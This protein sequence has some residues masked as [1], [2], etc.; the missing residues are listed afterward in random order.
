MWVRAGSAYENDNEA[1]IAHV[2]EHMLFKGTK[3]RGVGGIAK[4]VD[5]AGGYINAYTSIDMTVYHLAIAS[6]YFDTG[7]DIISDAIQNSSFDPEELKKEESVILEELKMG[8]DEPS[9]RAYEELFATAYE[10]HSYRRPIIGYEETVKSLT[11]E[12]ILNFYKQ[13]YVPNN[14]VFVVVGDFKAEEALKKIKNSF[15]DFK[16]SPLPEINIPVEPVQMHIRS[17]I[18][19]DEIKEANLNFAFHIPALNHEDIPVLDIISVILGQGESSRLYKKIKSDLNLVNSISSYSMTPKYPGLFLAGAAL[20]KEKI[21]EAILPILEEVYLLKTKEVTSEELEKAKLILESDFVYDRETVQGEA[22]KLGYF[23]T[24]AGG[25]DFE[26]KYI[27]AIKNVTTADIK[28]VAEKYFNNSNLTATVLAPQ[29]G[30]K[31]I[32]P[33]EIIALALNAEKKVQEIPL[34]QTA[35]TKPDDITKRILPNGITLLIKEDHEMPIVA[36]NAVFLA[37]TRFEPENKDGISSFTSEMLTKG[38]VIRNADDIAKEVESIAGSLQSFSGK[39][40]FGIKAKLLSRFLDNGFNLISDIILNPSFD[41]SEF[42]KKKKE[43]LLAIKNQDDD[44]THLVSNLFNQL[45]YQK[46]P[47]SRDVLG[48]KESISSI[49]KEDLLE[50]YKKFAV[51][52]N[53]VFTVVGD[54]KTENVSGKIENAFRNLKKETFSMP[55]ISDPSPLETNKSSIIYR[56]KKQA[57]I[58]LGFLGVDNHDPDRYALEV[59]SNI[60]SGQGGRLFIEL[61]DKQSLA[62][63]VT[64]INQIRM[65]KGVFAAYIGTSPEKIDKAIEGIK[66]ELIKLT[67]EKVG[68]EEL[69]RTKKSMIGNFEIGLQKR[70][71]LASEIAFSERYGL[72]FDS[73]KKYAERI[74]A[75][76]S[77][78]ILNVAKKYIDFN[79][80]ALAIIRPEKGSSND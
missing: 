3:K 12:H 21:K 25:L 32:F 6:R 76:T 13:W 49:K 58:L 54:V 38:T 19:Y 35:S 80:Y 2:F 15:A 42:E 39:D 5:E 11:R 34:E 7:L 62:Y 78:D 68:D 20:E 70:A 40:S 50:F 9:S 52:E 46:H 24:I 59:L 72:G 43:I 4:E 48:T 37:G 10:K 8:K 64:S 61:R 29:A 79:H 28:K 51:P 44:L 41:E 18:S 27:A 45:L 75:V 53:L 69:E 17:K 65:D 73:Y 60:L 74:S 55:E 30:G 16:S 67:Q 23:E 36:I 71:A 33:Q 63:S 26:E 56:D 22:K 47:Y 57:H 14:M 77:E 1:G 31:D 66:N